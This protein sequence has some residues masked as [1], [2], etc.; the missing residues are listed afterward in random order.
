MSA[1]LRNV[2]TPDPL[3][4]GIL[5]RF[6]RDYPVEAIPKATRERAKHLMLDALGIAFA[7][8][9]YPF[10]APTLAGARALGGTGNTPVIGMNT[11]LGLRDAIMVN[12]VLLH[13]LD[14]DDTHVP[15]VIHATVSV[16]PTVL[17]QGA[18]LGASGRDVLAAY[19]IGV[20]TGARIAAAAKGGFHDLGFHPTGLVGAF[21]CT[22]A[23]GRLAGLDHEA[24]V[25]A[26]GI[27]LSLAGGSL[28]F[29]EDGSWTK[30]LHPGW[31]GVAGVT[32]A[33]L[34]Q[35]G[36]KG[37]QRAYEGRFGLYATHLRN[38]AG[39][40]EL[41][42]ALGTL[43]QAWEIHAVAVKPFPLCHF[44]H[45]CADAAIA[46][47]R[48]G[49][50]PG[51]IR[52]VTARLPEGTMP[53]VCEPIADKRR[54]KNEYDAKFSIPF[55][56]A[57]GLRFGRVGLAE[58][59]DAHLVDPGTLALAGRVDCVI[60]PDADFPRYYPG[61]VRVELDDGR[62]IAHREPVNRGAAD[63][64]ITEAEIVAKF[65]EN[66]ALALPRTRAERLCELVLSL[67]TQAS[68]ADLDQALA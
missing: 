17:A 66:A 23:A 60:D 33:T 50:D 46:I 45:A 5:A 26:Q 8:T 62:V 40:A 32:A 1:V 14:Y 63:R 30:R 29:L 18:A 59:G 7:S 54:P 3:A 34:A 25:K 43:G 27:A 11:R 52:R 16:L 24:L 64:P 55:V 68:L 53:V 58:L 67:D 47:H 2:T 57:S 36:F 42:A 37:P 6:A 9:T 22:L 20:E 65:H 28:E 38:G 56:V 35:H 48:Q 39:A 19:V 51:R 49:V 31:A 10:A 12:G 13:G 15:G 44:T 41:E 61:E 4:S 21:A